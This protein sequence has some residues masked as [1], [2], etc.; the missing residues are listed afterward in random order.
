LR[1]HMLECVQIA[2]RAYTLVSGKLPP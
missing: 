1:R 2:L